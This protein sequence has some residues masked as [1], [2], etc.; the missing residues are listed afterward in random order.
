MNQAGTEGVHSDLEDLLMTNRAG[1]IFKKT[2]SLEQAC[3][4]VSALH[5]QWKE[6][7]WLAE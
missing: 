3:Q 4:E 5:T 2:L 6:V 1:N 7:E